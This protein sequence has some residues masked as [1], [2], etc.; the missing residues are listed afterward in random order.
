MD[1]FFDELTV[2]ML[3]MDQDCDPDTFAA[4]IMTWTMTEGC[5]DGF[6]MMGF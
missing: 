4:L 1:N 5:A 2:V 6:D 3:A